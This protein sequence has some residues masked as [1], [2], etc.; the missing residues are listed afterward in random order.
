MDNNEPTILTHEEQQ[1]RA[2][3]VAAQKAYDDMVESYRRAGM[4]M[5]NRMLTM[6][7][8]QI[9]IAKQ[10]VR[11]LARKGHNTMTVGQ[12]VRFA[13]ETETENNNGKPVTVPAGAIGTIE[14]VINASALYVKVNGRKVI[15]WTHE[16]EA[17]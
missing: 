3:V 17:L 13:D 9:L 11:D 12:K 2:A 5:N 14:K 4:G 6:L 10:R 1:A 7:D 8:R 15:V 16:V